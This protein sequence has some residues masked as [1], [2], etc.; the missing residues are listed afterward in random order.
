MSYRCMNLRCEN[1]ADTETLPLDYAVGI[2]ERHDGNALDPGLQVG[3]RESFDIR[4]IDQHLGPAIQ[5]V[6]VAVRQAA[7]KR[8]VGF[9]SRRVSDVPK[10]GLFAR[11][12]SSYHMNPYL[13]Q[14]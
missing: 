9:G 12:G 1:Y 8:Q 4:R 2:D 14:S 11:Q 7:M 13:R 10:Q 5:V 3:I 6:G